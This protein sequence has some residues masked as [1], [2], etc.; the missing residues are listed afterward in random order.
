[1]WRSKR[2]GAAG[3]ASIAAGS[4]TATDDIVLRAS[5]IGHCGAADDR[6][7]CKHRRF[8]RAGGR[9]SQPTEADGNDIDVIAGSIN[10]TTA[11][12]NGTGSDM[13]LT[14]SSGQLTLARDRGDHRHPHQAGHDGRAPGHQQPDLRRQR[15]HQTRRPMHACECHEQHRQCVGHGNRRSDRRQPYRNA[16]QRD[17]R[18][19]A[20]GS[21]QHGIGGYDIGVGAG[22]V[23]IGTAGAGGSLRPHRERAAS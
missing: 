14:A 17:R 19:W 23:L 18:G 20:A 10:V 15:D 1:M 16:G 8:K 6:Y 22:S 5:G 11:A 7:G 9:P 12:A 13:R 21:V 4:I 3:A 2:G